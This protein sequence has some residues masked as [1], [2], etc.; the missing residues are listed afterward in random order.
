M[1]NQQMYADLHTELNT[2]SPAQV[3]AALLAHE[4]VTE[5]TFRNMS[6]T[7]EIRGLVVTK[8][9]LPQDFLAPLDDAEH[10]A[11][12]QRVVKMIQDDETADN[13][14]IKKDLVNDLL[15]VLNSLNVTDK[16]KGLSD[17]RPSIAIS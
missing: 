1:G 10:N 12:L 8:H 6:L 11:E 3:L 14:V 7:E 2:K 9:G 17:N 5:D 13:S 16:M 4:S 15:D